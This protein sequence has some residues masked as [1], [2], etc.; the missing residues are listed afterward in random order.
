MAGQECKSGGA[1]GHEGLRGKAGELEEEAVA[2]AELWRQRRRRR[3]PR[4]MERQGG[5]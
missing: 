1:G 4:A 3:K 5:D 2:V